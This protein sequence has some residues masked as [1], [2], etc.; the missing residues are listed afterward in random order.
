[1]LKCWRTEK[2]GSGPRRG[3]S[4]NEP[5]EGASGERAIQQG[6]LVVVQPWVCEDPLA[7]VTRKGR[8]VK[9][10][11]SMSGV[12]GCPRAVVAQR[13]GYDVVE[14]PEFMQTA[15]K[16]GT[17]HEDWVA[18]DLKELGW[19]VSK[20]V[21]C[22]RCGRNGHHVELDF[23]A[24]KL[25]GH[26]DRLAWRDDPKTRV[27]IEDSDRLVEIKSLGRF[28][29]EKLIK[30][31]AHDTF[32]QEFREYAMQVSCYHHASNVPIL[33]VVKNRDTGKLVTF[34]I[35]APYSREYI[36]E[37]VLELELRARKDSLPKCEYRRGDF[38][39]T[40]CAVKYMCAGEDKETEVSTLREKQEEKQELDFPAFKLVGHVDVA[41]TQETALVNIRPD[42]DSKVTALYQEGIKL[43]QR[44]E[45]RVVQS[46]DDVEDATNDLSLVARLKKAIEEKRKEY[47]G[48]LN[49]HLKNVNNVF[50]TFAE[51][52]NQADSITRR[53]VLDYR[54][55]Q[56][57]IRQEQERINKLREEAAQAERELKGEVTEPIGLVV[58]APVPRTSYQTESG[59]LGKAKVWKFEVVSF[60]LLPNDYKLADITKIRRVVTAGV[61]IPGVRAW[62][63][64]SLRVTTR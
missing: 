19:K 38:E 25:V 49:E 60:E 9:P 53:K 1:M 28:R 31:L 39:R 5:S 8:L 54:V 10:T 62:Q 29:A 32:K 35:E 46:D 30:A 42:T 16:E 52:L 51:P 23:P 15:A 40:I 4:C 44:A 57:R 22:L 21:V 26:M 37:Y 61:A 13:L 63:E 47:V 20:P 33:Y 55:G 56:E 11:Y 58:V 27:H 2:K 24:F 17:R 12:G 18:E 59:T 36:S 43:Q 7:P 45:L 6:L 48:P 14:P 3:H 64:E 50:K 34:E 41:V